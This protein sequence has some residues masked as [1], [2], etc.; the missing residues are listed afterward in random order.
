MMRFSEAKA[1]IFDL[2]GTLLAST[3]LWYG[4][5]AKAL[6]HFGIDM[7]EDY[8]AHVNHLDI[9]GGTAYTAARFGLACGA[10]GVAQVWR[11]IAGD[12][13]RERIDLTPHAKEL[14]YAL[15]SADKTLAIATALDRD[16][17]QA[18]MERHGVWQ[19]FD[20]FV[21]VA[22]VGKDKSS[23]DVYIAAA[24][25]LGAEPSECVVVEDG[26]VGA[27]S[28]HAAGFFTAGVKDPY[29]GATADMMR[30]VCDRLEDDLGG[31]LADFIQNP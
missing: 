14:L 23:P 12:A 29:S 16:L 3:G 28:A 15:K 8:V 20:A 7:P 21:S 30:S 17:A 19:L 5:Y 1:Y 22:D 26:F 24:E 27:R 2:D 11:S 9:A 31:Y 13:Y 10:E 6:A 4:V 25:A 18:C